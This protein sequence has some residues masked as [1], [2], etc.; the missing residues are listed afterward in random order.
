MSS[1]WLNNHLFAVFLVF[2]PIFF[3]AVAIAV[4]DLLAVAAL[5]KLA[6]FSAIAADIRLRRSSTLRFWRVLLFQIEIYLQNRFGREIFRN[7]S[8]AGQP[9]GRAFGLD[10]FLVILFGLFLVFDLEVLQGDAV[11][12][13]RN[14]SVVRFAG[15]DKIP[16]TINHPE[17]VTI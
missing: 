15:G 3:L 13:F 16:V 14:V 10:G 4:L 7:G 6:G 9:D 12:S 8:E 11:Q 2:L 5:T 1:S 17:G